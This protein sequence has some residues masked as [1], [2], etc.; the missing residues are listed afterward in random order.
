MNVARSPQHTARA[1]LVIAVGVTFFVDH[2]ARAFA[3]VHTRG[4]ITPTAAGVDAAFTPSHVGGIPPTTSNNPEPINWDNE[5]LILLNLICL[6]IRCDL[7][8]AN[9]D[10]VDRILALSGDSME[11]SAASLAARATID[12]YLEEG[13]LP[14]LTPA[15]ASLGIQRCQTLRAHVL[16]GMGRPGS[17]GGTLA[18]ELADT[19]NAMIQDLQSITS[20]EFTTHHDAQDGTP[21][22]PRHHHN[23]G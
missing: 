20:V 12:R 11:V 19:L 16:F 6:I 15:Q 5:F 13:L 21:G 2:G 3:P 17:L 4:A 23:G 10:H 8:S 18:A 1:C 22:H 7:D 14:G 9:P